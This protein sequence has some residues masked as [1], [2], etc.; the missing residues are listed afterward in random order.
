[1][2]SLYIVLD[3]EKIYVYDASNMDVNE[4]YRGLVIFGGGVA[5]IGII[6]ALGEIAS[7]RL[8]FEDEI[9]KL[10]DIAMN[11]GGAWGNDP[12]AQARREMIERAES[13]AVREARK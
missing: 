9:H 12:D 1:M 4:V 7:L 11:L 2:L 10:A 8:R 5:A 6:C 13:G 3:K